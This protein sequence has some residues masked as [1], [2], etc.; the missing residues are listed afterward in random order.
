[1]IKL[2][3]LRRSEDIMMCW[4]R[5]HCNEPTVRKNFLRDLVFA[6]RIVSASEREGHRF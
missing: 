1:V 2:A 4:S 3:L 6:K 5:L